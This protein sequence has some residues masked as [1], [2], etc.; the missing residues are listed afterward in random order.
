MATEK[1]VRDGRL[2][3]LGVAQEQHGDR[4]ALFAQWYKIDWPILHDPINLMGVGGVP[5]VVAIDEHGVVRKLRPRPDTLEQDFLE[6]R[7]ERPAQLEAGLSCSAPDLDALASHAKQTD[8]AQAW[9]ELGDAITL[10][11]GGA[12]SDEAV[13]AY[14]RA[15]Q[16]DPKDGDAHFRL[17]VALRMRY[18]T[19]RRRPGDFQLA[20]DSWTQARSID[21]NRYIW[22]RRVEQ[23]GPRL[24][25]PYPFYDW[26]AQAVSEI[27]ARGEEPVSLRTLPYGSELSQPA[28]EFET[29]SET[30]REPDPDGSILR[31]TG[32]LVEIEVVVV[33]PTIR[34]DQTARL[35]VA[36]FP[37]AV[38]KVHW[39]N[40]APPLRLWLNPP[41]GWEVSRQLLTV[42][43]PA[44]SDSSTALR[45]DFE[46]KAPSTATGTAQLS[47]Y[48]LY[49]VCED[50][51][52][53]C[54]YLRQDTAIEVQAK[55]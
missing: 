31:D 15:A 7:Y 23:Y 39:N 41:L 30:E 47:A 25:K 18:E 6:K 9:R 43:N 16:I 36:C 35:H 10:W 22:R 44:Q 28:R 55:D 8:T 20:V 24:T 29:A 19:S 40:E 33:P 34:P 14:S 48:A 11:A 2:V 5:V 26:V 1:W 42:P 50:I 17:G 52:G 54:R 46:V 27:R 49:Y 51:Q 21:P 12:R 37:S 4:C 53:T 3:V 45:L 13:D 38:Q 32:R